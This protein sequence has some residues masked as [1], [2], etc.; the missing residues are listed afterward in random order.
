[1]SDDYYEELEADRKALRKL[2]TQLRA[3]NARLREA[4]KEYGSH[5]PNCDMNKFHPYGMK[6]DCGFEQALAQKEGE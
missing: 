4:F 2:N 6:C 1:M 3:D 5:K